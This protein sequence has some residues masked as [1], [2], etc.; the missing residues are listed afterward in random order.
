MEEVHLG[1]FHRE[2]LEAVHSGEAHQ[3]EGHRS[4]KL[5][6]EEEELRTEVGQEAWEVQPGR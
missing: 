3:S 2:E 1:A 5:L 4:R 6:S